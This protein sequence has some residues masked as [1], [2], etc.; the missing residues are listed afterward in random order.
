M[1]THTTF[2]P[3][4]AVLLWSDTDRIF[5]SL[6]S[7]TGAPVILT[8]S[9]T[10]GGLSKAL[11]LLKSR[12]KRSR[13]PRSAPPPMGATAGVLTIAERQTANGLA[14]L[15]KLGMLDRR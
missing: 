7:K 15:K 12:A 4:H 5:A 6:P 11:D 3:P 14:V 13:S 9:H 1:T 2:H 10:E 8:F